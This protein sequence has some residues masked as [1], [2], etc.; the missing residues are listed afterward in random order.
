MLFRRLK[1]KL[2]KIANF[3]CRNLILVYIT[4]ILS[5]YKSKLSENKLK[6]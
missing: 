1:P 3:I 2:Q 4:F 6:I 5:L